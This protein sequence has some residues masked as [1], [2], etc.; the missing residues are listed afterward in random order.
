MPVDKAVACIRGKLEQDPTLK[1]RTDM[2]PDDIAKLLRFC[3]GCTYFVFDKQ[4]Y[5]QIH[6]AAMGSPI[7]MIVCDGYME[8]IEE[9]AI[10]TAPHP[11]HWW[12]RYVD[13]THTKLDKEFAQEFTDHLNSLDP[14]IKFTTEEEE[15]GGLAF[16][17]TNTVKCEEGSLKVTIYRKPTHTDQ[18]LSFESNHPLDHKLSVVRTLMHRAHTVITEEQDRKQEV[19]H[20]T[21]ALKNCGYPDWAIRRATAPTPEQ[22][23]P[24]P[25][26]TR[27]ERKSAPVALPY[28]KGL[29]EEL[30]RLFRSYG[31]NTYVKPA[32][33]LRQML[34]APKDPAKKEETAGVIYRVD[35]EGDG[36]EKC[37]SFYIGE[38]GRT[39]K[40][41]AAEHRRPSTTTSE[42]SQHLHLKGRPAHQVSM[43]NIKILDREQAWFPRGVK[44][45]L[46]IRML[47]PD[48]N[49]DGGRHQLP[50]LW[51]DLLGS[52]DLRSCDSTQ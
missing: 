32:N 39:L 5:R 10:S 44:E 17:D 6:G 43:D 22:R 8:D 20:V 52:H 41:R 3:L 30:R 46:Y 15:E 26:K 16:L 19:D 51:D 18:Y 4:Y 36:E 42:V 13:D 24:T 1:G 14:D 12:F 11:P 40:A 27:P 49:R 21:K 28:T 29:S 23:E 37:E 7:S 9:R 35:C 50:H 33:T 31:C 47:R 2:A 48:L 25:T 34:C 38:T 45:S